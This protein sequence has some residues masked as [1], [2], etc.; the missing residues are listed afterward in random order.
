MLAEGRYADA[1]VELRQALRQ[2]Q[3]VRAPYLVARTRELAAGAYAGLEDNDSAATE[4][5]MA[6]D[7]YEALGA[8]DDA[9]RSRSSQADSAFPGG[10][11]QRETEVLSCVAGGQSNREVAA[12]L[13]ISEK[14]V[15]R[16]L[17]NIFT[18]LGVNSRTE[19]AAFAFDHGVVAHRRA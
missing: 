1:L 11:T 19:A 13:F 4:L 14:T 3:E 2:W 18:K 15:A 17:S 6:H 16:H 7:E 9:R 8:S 5:S 10:L 12:T